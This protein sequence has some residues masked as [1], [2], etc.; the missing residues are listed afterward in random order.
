MP[1]ITNQEKLF[2]EYDLEFVSKGPKDGMWR[3][4]YL[5]CPN[6]G[7]YVLKGKGYDECL[8]GNISIDSDYMRITVLNMPESEIETFK[9]IKKKYKK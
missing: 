2:R 5:K 1:N 8:C 7:Y 4:H 3:C 6:C 9:A